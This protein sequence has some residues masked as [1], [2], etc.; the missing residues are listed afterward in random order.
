MQNCCEDKEV[1]TSTDEK[2]EEEDGASNITMQKEEHPTLRKSTR[3]IKV[4]DRY[5]C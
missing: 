2:D 1:T 4:P 5:M 3:T